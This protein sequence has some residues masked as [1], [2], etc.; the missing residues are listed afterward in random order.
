[1]KSQVWSE[2]KVAIVGVGTTKQGLHPGKSAYELAVA[3]LK[4]AIDDAGI[5]D[6]SRIDGLLGGRQFTD[7]T[8]IDPMEMSRLL[9][10]EPRVT[11][12]LDYGTGGFT[13]Q[14]GAMLIAT[15][16]C[17]LVA[18]VFGRNPSNPMEGLSGGRAYNH[19]HGFVNSASVAALGWTQH[20]ARYGTTEEALGHVMLNARNHARL[21]PIAAWTDPLTIEDY[22][23]Q[24]YVIWPFRSYDIC[25][26]TAG[27][28]AIIMARG[29]IARD[30]AKQPVFMHAVGRQQ[31]PRLLEDED[32]F[33][34]RNMRGAAS[35]VYSAAGMTPKDI[36]ALYIS[37]ASTAAVLLTLENFGFCDEGEC[38]DFVKRGAIGL[39]G[40]L[41]VNTSGGQLSEGYLVGWLHHAELVRQLRG[42]CGERQVRGAKV[43]QYCTTGRIRED[44][45]SSIYVT[46]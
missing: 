44:F 24:P 41:P 46:D 9:G 15:G 7:G 5:T 18:C 37:D 1:M 19:D 12:A 31:A 10:L 14:Y 16:T 42:E 11:G 45:L 22:L 38:G 34:C 8:G 40:E 43:A 13:T 25:K 30:M 28:V 39:G 4:S 29:D 27:A 26:V 20:M 35:Q 3:A 36:D 33:L 32:H 17:D 6:K 23:A 21:N 2:R